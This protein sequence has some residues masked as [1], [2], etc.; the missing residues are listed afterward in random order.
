MRGL[1]ILLLAGCGADGSACKEGSILVDVTLDGATAGADALEMMVSDGQS[2]DLT[3]RFQHDP[4][5]AAGSFELDLDRFDGQV[6][7]FTL[8]ALSGSAMLGSTS[9]TYAPGGRCG[10]LDLE[11]APE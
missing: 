1:F 9:F 2:P 3:V 7:T 11:V 6:R 8:L 5:A 10:A 4:G